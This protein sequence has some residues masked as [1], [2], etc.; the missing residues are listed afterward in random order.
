MASTKPIGLSDGRAFS[1]PA[2]RLQPSQSHSTMPTVMALHILS[3]MIRLT[4]VTEAAI[5]RLL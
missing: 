5:Y 2:E 4:V 3:F 1:A